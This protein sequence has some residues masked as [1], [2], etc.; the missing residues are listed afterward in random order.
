MAV[1]FLDSG[2]ELLGV[3]V[4]RSTAVHVIHEALNKYNDVV[5]FSDFPF[6]VAFLTHFLAGRQAKQSANKSSPECC[7]TKIKQF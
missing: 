3:I 2:E 7:G 4:V 5:A 6:C 1:C